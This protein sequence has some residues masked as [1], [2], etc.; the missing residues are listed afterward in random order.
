[1][2]INKYKQLKT[3]EEKLDALLDIMNERFYRL[4]RKIKNLPDKSYVQKRLDEFEARLNRL[5]PISA[6]QSG[7]DGRL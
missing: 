1:M 3:T 6:L 4:E 5:I 2:D 7:H